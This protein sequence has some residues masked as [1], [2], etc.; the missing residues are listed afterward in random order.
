MLVKF[1]FQIRS[2]KTAKKFRGY[3]LPQIRAA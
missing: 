3:F 2:E 1:R